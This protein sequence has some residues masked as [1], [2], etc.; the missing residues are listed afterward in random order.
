MQLK[1][2]S[3]TITC[4]SLPAYSGTSGLCAGLVVHGNADVRFPAR[5][6]LLCT[7]ITLQFEDDLAGLLSDAE[8]CSVNAAVP[9]LH[10]Q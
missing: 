4:L 2:K 8:R 10:I 6:S 3:V 9:S 1:L 5:D 7:Q